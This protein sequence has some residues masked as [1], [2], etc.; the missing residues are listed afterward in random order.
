MVSFV[1][2]TESHRTHKQDR[3]TERQTDIK[4]NIRSI[5]KAGVKVRF[6]RRW[7]HSCGGCHGCL[8]LFFVLVLADESL[9]PVCIVAL[10]VGSLLAKVSKL[11]QERDAV[12]EMLVDN[13]YLILKR[14]EVCR[15]GP[16]GCERLERKGEQQQST[17]EE[18]S[19]SGQQSPQCCSLR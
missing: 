12:D 19:S 1:I 10:N 18:G 16:L 15:F 3:R 8:F 6:Q 11:V 2:D 4:S 14:L 17:R 9:D 5:R 13:R 7:R